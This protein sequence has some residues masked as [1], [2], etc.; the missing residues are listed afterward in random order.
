MPRMTL[1]P[2][3]SLKPGWLRLEMADL[4]LI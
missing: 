1:G 4:K 3:L 2:A